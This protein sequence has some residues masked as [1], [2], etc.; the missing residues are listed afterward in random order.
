[1][2]EKK[3]ASVLLYLVTEEDYFILHRLTIA[4]AALARGYRVVILTCTQDRTEF[5][6]QE[7][8]IVVPLRCFKRAS[9][10]PLRELGALAEIIFYYQKY[11]PSLVHHIALKPI[12]Y[13]SIAAMFLPVRAV[14]N[15]FAGMGYLF[16]SIQRKAR[17]LRPIVQ[18]LLK[19]I[20]ARPNVRVVVENPTDAILM[21][22][23]GIQPTRVELIQGPGVDTNLY[24][25]QSSMR[26]EKTVVTLVGRLLEDKGVRELVEAARILHAWNVEVDINIVG[27]PD[28]G[29][30]CAI[31][32]SEMTD[33]HGAGLIHWYGPQ[34]NSPKIWEN[35]D[36]AVLPSYR[37]GLPKSLLEASSMG[38]PIVATNVPGCRDVV[39]NGKTGLL[40]PPRDALALAEAIKTLT[41]NPILRA[42]M[43]KAGR[44]RVCDH[45]ANEIIAKQT[46]NLYQNLLSA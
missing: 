24:Q 18:R 38:I 25:P 9:M 16:S 33:W 40:V 34:E 28:P 36:I 20:C 32:E 17:F 21:E 29:N 43:G 15:H 3:K 27:A 7:G 23:L 5:L 2:S 19:L 35:T 8:F 13:G 44:A 41:L 4:K 42:E 14:V 46:V 45:F 12:L 22:K 30:P 31:L 11:R 6:R 26:K 39:E 10:N 1:M 37:E